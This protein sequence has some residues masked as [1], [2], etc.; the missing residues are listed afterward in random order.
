MH[1]VYEAL[2]KP[3]DG[4]YEYQFTKEIKELKVHGLLRKATSSSPALHLTKRFR[5]QLTIRWR[6]KG[7]RVRADIIIPQAREADSVQDFF[8]SFYDQFAALQVPADLSSAC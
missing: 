8:V 2:S 1:H 4:Q 5:M 3:G 6:Q 7:L